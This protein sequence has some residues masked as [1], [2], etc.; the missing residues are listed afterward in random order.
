VLGGF[1]RAEWNLA[2]ASAR[3]V[4]ERIESILKRLLMVD[5]ES[6]LRLWR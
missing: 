1:V 6:A 2:A 3:P 5:P 4:D